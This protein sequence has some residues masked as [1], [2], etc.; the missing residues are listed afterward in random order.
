MT[1][2]TPPMVRPLSM[3]NPPHAALARDEGH[4]LNNRVRCLIVSLNL[5]DCELSG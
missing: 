4:S 3:F 2:I 1:A 5:G